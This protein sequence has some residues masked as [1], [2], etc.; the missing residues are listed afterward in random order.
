MA[1][2][3]GRVSNQRKNTRRAHDAK[4]PANLVNCRNCGDKRMPH[5]ICQ[6]CGAYSNRIV[7]EVDEG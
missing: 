5:T 2:P 6:S 1:V 4:K 7:V 3:R